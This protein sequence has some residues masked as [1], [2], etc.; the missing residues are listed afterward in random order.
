VGD[1]YRIK[2]RAKG[3]QG[4]GKEKQVPKAAT[5]ERAVPKKSRR[6][7]KF[8]AGT[9]RFW[10]KMVFEVP[11]LVWAEEI[12]LFSPD[13]KHQQNVPY[14]VRDSLQ[15]RKESSRGLAEKFMECLCLY[16]S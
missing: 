10:E 5:E 11:D 9:H 15:F 12:P 13:P 3:I 1:P 4:N 2:S 16:M 6:R 7:T 8:A 14:K